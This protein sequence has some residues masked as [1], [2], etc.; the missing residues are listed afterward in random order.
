MTSTSTDRH[1]G[2][3]TIGSGL[4]IGPEPMDFP[5]VGRYTLSG[6]AGARVVVWGVV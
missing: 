6:P 4:T 1:G 5:K 3:S 2:L